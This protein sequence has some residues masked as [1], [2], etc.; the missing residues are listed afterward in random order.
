MALPS[1]PRSWSELTW[2]QL[3]LCWE[4]KL[5]YGDN[6]DV[7]RAAALLALCGC[8]VCRDIIST[9]ATTGEIV[10]TLASADGSRWTV[11]PRIL[12]QTARHALPWFDFPYGD[13]GEPAEKDEKGKVIR[14]ARTP[15]NGYV[16]PMLDALALP[17]TELQVDGTWFALPQVACNNI[18]WQQYRSIQP[19]MPQ[20][21]QEGQTEEQILELQA[22]FLAYILVPDLPAAPSSVPADRF[23]PTHSYRYVAERAEQ[24]IPFWRKRMA[25]VNAS[26]SSE[27]KP[28]NGP[29]LFHICFQAYHTAALYYEKAYPLLFGSGAKSQEY[30]DALKGESGT[31]NAVMKYAG[32]SSQQE[33]YDSNLPFVLD[34]L[35]AIVKEAKEIEKM[36]AKIKKK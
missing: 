6:A 11:T 26:S 3:C 12:S 20:L 16:G 21:F 19:L 27:K 8:S 29:V 2:Q 15:V 31:L 30:T 33:V 28:E 18:T 24:T 25:K 22:Q 9:D 1:L 10:Y 23:R 36:N 17:E 7:A 35:N 4:T 14:E 32:Y 13:P 34:I 5:R